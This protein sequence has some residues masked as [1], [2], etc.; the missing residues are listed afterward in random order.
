MCNESDVFQTKRN[1]DVFAEVRAYTL[2]ST[3]SVFVCVGVL[4]VFKHSDPIY[5]LI[6][7][8]S[9]VTAGPA[10]VS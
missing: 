5:A 10:G 2:H 8:P 4:Q 1:G 7:Q 3:D 9:H 6:L